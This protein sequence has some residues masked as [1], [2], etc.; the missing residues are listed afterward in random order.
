MPPLTAETLQRLAKTIVR[1]TM[2]GGGQFEIK[3]LVELAP[4]SS[5]LFV[6]RASRGY[7]TGLT[8]H[9]ILPN[10][11]IQ[12]GSPG[13]NEFMGGTRYMIDEPGRTSQ[14]RG[15]V[16]TSTRGR[17]TG[18]GQ[19]YINLVDTP[20]L[21]HEYSIFAEVVRGMD[22]VDRILEGDA[23]TKVEVVVR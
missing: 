11:L 9:R 8:F 3:P 5:A 6:D 4:V 14:L 13:A 1:V 15:T 16:G 17:D 7:Y 12:G 18:D 22:V 21:D 20:R 2:A 19:I 10:F 23:M